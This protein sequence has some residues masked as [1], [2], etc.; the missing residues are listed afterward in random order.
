MPSLKWDSLYV[1]YYFAVIFNF[2]N[3]GLIPG[4]CLLN[5]NFYSNSTPVNKDLQKYTQVIFTSNC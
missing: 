5:R 2:C 4:D 3:K 1:P